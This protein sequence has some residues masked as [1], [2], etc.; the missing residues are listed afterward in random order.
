MK[1]HPNVSNEILAIVN[2]LN[3]QSSGRKD[4]AAFTRIKQSL[5]AIAPNIEVEER[6][7]FSS[8]ER[9]LELFFDPSVTGDTER[10][11]YFLSRFHLTAL[12]RVIH[13]YRGDPDGFEAGIL[14]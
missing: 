12:Y 11:S 6:E 13:P 5:S 9:H 10:D 3:K 1:N 14:L 7:H 2:V 8:A 4:A